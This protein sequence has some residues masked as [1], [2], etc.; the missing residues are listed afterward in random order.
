MLDCTPQITQSV[1]T[2]RITQMVQYR[3]KIDVDCGNNIAQISKMCGQ[4]VEILSV[5]LHGTCNFL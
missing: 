3:A 5:K 2:K 1:Y 4:K